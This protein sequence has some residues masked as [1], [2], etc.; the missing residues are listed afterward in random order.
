MKSFRHNA[1][2]VNAGS[3]ADIAFLLLIFFLV[4]TTISVD[5]GINRKLPKNCPPGTI[6]NLD[7]H[8]RNVL[9][10][11]LNATN[12]ILVNNDIIAIEELKRI[13]KL[14]LD[15]NAD[16][17]CS[18]CNGKGENYLSDNPNKAIVSLQNNK[19]TSY[20]FYIAVQDEL[21]KAYS[22]LREQY[23]INVLGNSSGIFTKDEFTEI[24]AAYP[25]IV[26]E[27]EIK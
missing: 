19:L 12:E 15:N 10:I 4:T 11:S 9:K 1:P 20:I 6:C 7:T 8:Q 21:T 18:Y 16:K 26:S 24:K 2:E 25:F 3:M 23:A 17:S 22:E 27:A 14:F 5:K 13:T